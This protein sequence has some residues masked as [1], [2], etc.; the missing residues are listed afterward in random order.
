[1][2]SKP[3]QPSAAEGRAPNSSTRAKPKQAPATPAWP[4][5]RCKRD[6]ASFAALAGHN[7][8]PAEEATNTA[9]GKPPSG[10]R[11]TENREKFDAA[12][13][14]VMAQKEAVGGSGTPYAFS[15]SYFEQVGAG[16]SGASA[17]GKGD[18]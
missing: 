17:G 8:N 3:S 16:E 12:L 15:Q 10:A 14:K 1:M 9:A 5:S 4:C 11:P 18:G 7:C 2:G 13:E 6:F